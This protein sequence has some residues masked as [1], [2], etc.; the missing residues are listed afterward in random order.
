MY[1]VSGSPVVLGDGGTGIASCVDGV[2]SSD[3]YVD[4][5]DTC[6]WDWALNHQDRIQCGKPRLIPFSDTVFSA[7][8]GGYSASKASMGLRLSSPD[9]LPEGLLILG[10]SQTDILSDS[11]C[12]FSSDPAQ[13]VDYSPPG[14]PARGNIRIV[15][16]PARQICLLNSEQG[17]LLLDNPA[18]SLIPPGKINIPS[19]PRHHKS[20]AMYVGVQT[21]SMSCFGRPIFDLAFGP[22]GDAYV[23]P[24]VVQPTG[25]GGLSCRGPTQAANWSPTPLPTG[26]AL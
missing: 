3:G 5:Y 26:S 24:V 6:S 4:F 19:D 22:D 7:T 8:S 13:A 23:A 25:P 11:L 20:A 17:V 9:P 10:K 1:V 18:K 15:S 2:F 21:G 16:N 12:F 14:L